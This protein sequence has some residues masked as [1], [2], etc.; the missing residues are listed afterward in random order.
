[1]ATTMTSQMQGLAINHY[2]LPL[3]A[4]GS[5]RMESGG[6]QGLDVGLCMCI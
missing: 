6:K 1:M 4:G 5:W 3:T 2:N